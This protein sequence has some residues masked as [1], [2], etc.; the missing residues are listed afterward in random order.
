MLFSILHVFIDSTKMPVGTLNFPGLYVLTR[1]YIHTAHKLPC[2]WPFISTFNRKSDLIFSNNFLI[3]SS[4]FSSLLTI[5]WLWGYASDSNCLD[6]FRN[7]AYD[8]SWQRC[9]LAHC[10]CPKVTSPYTTVFTST[11]ASCVCIWQALSTSKHTR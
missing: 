5:L 2:C 1:S 3:P 7:L 6:S 10:R 4:V 9:A 8:T 11:P